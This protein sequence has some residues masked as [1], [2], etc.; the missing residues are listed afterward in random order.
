[1]TGCALQAF[2][3]SRLE[4]SGCTVR[5]CRQA[6]V[7]FDSARATVE[8]SCL[9]L[10][11]QSFAVALNDECYAALHR[12]EV[13]QAPLPQQPSTAQPPDS[14]PEDSGA[15][16]ARSGVLWA[17]PGEPCRGCVGAMRCFSERGRGER[18]F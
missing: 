3:E 16:V 11:P 17:S 10:P 14:N 6:L 8:D 7:L 18:A 1:M 13:T 9:N 12:V 15:S 5:W 2:D 4:L